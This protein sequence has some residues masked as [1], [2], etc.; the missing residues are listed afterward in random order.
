MQASSAR[1]IFTRKE[2]NNRLRNSGEAWRPRKPVISGPLSFRSV[3]TRSF[4]NLSSDNE[5]ESF[6]IAHFT[7]RRTA[8]RRGTACLHVSPQLDS[9]WLDRR[10][11][12][13]CALGILDY[14][15]PEARYSQ[16]GVLAILL[17]KTS[18]KD[19]SAAPGGCDRRVVHGAALQDRV[20]RLS[21]VREQ[22]R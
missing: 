9:Q 11:Y 8:G 16:P 2:R 19:S 1:K 21:A 7:A 18:H 20:S 6:D 4:S 22:H 5:F 3:K 12:F 14:R 15:H 17:H 10:R 13:F